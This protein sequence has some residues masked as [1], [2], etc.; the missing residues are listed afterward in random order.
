M[1]GTSHKGTTKTFAGPD[2]WGRSGRF[3]PHARTSSTHNP[4]LPLPQRKAYPGFKVQEGKQEGGM[5]GRRSSH[6]LKH[7]KLLGCSPR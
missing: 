1:Q 3:H 7:D 2:P 6:R 4:W 5:G